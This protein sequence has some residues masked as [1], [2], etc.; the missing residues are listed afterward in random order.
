M[1]SSR[2]ALA[3]PGKRGF[4]AR[5]GRAIE[6]F[7][8]APA[9]ATPLAALR[10]G[11]VLV[12]LVQ[13]ARIAPAFFVFY[14]RSGVLQGPLR[15]ELARPGLP[16]LGWLFRILG[17]VGMG[18][19]TILVSTGLVYVAS[20]I[21]LLLGWRTRMAA[22]VAWLTHLTLMMT[23]NGTSYGADSFGNIFLFYLIWIPS[24]AA[25]SMDRLAGRQ[26]AGPTPAA[27]LSL[28]VIQ[29]HLCLIYLTS[30]LMKWSGEQW[31]DGD[32]IW[33]SLM[34]PEY[35]QVDSCWLV[36]HPWFAKLSGW[37]V[38][39]VE[40]GYSIFIWPR[41]TRRL[42]ILATV[43][44]HLGIAV[45]MGLGVFG[46]LMIALTVAAFGVSA[47]PGREGQRVPPQRG[48]SA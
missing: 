48:P 23:A 14:E 37:M 35:R 27:R 40:T 22:A 17:R 3:A 20:L 8:L 44:M 41:R 28:R 42:W 9:W 43:A 29:L 33:P 18:E 34:L 2:D 30:G 5:V 11:L 21:T 13:A 24:G 47:G 46:A 15:D 7:F 26:P 12:L 6:R 4:P 1:S 32:A 39:V 16:Y 45:F 36:D 38:I 10:I 31:W 19:T 25:L